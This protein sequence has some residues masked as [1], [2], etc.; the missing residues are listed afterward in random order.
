MI[1]TFTINNYV[2]TAM[3]DFAS[4]DTWHREHRPTLSEVLIELTPESLRLVATDTHVL[5]ALHLTAADGHGVDLSC[6]APIA[7]TLPMSTLKP[8]LRERKRPAVTV[9]ID[10]ESMTATVANA[11]G[12]QATVACREGEAYVAYHNVIPTTKAQPREYAAV[13][14]T[15][16]A[17]FGSLAKALG[18][19]PYVQVE[20]REHGGPIAVTVQSLPCCYGLLMPVSTHEW[21]GLPT[22]L[23]S[24]VDERISSDMLP[25]AA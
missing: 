1:A 21:L 6:V 8:L 7:V 12:M 9:T 13:D 11:V 2:L 20:F 19:S 17:K 25:V 22:W 18:V 14:V 24:P 15:L 23:Q 3:A 16:L 5:A 4:T 10:T